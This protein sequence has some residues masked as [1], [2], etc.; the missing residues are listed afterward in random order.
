MS[1][2]GDTAVSKIVLALRQCKNLRRLKLQLQTFESMMRL[3]T[4]ESESPQEHPD[5]DDGE[6]EEEWLD[7]IEEIW[8]DEHPI[9]S[10]QK[11]KQPARASIAQRRGTRDTL[12]VVGVFSSY[13]T[14]R[15][16]SE[17]STGPQAVPCCV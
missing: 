2:P 5:G 6:E 16:I 3:L 9:A 10:A 13:L 11:H 15:R 12:Q 4:P 14:T 17:L 1:G 8:Q 7:P